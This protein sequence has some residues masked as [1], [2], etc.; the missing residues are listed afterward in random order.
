MKSSTETSP[1]VNPVST[2]RYMCSC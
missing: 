2:T 1:D